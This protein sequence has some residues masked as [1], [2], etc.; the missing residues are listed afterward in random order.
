MHQ[1]TPTPP[2]GRITTQRDGHVLLIGID[3]AKKLNGFSP[4]MLI[5]LAQAMTTL[6]KD[7]AAW[8]GLIYAEG[9]N[10]TAGLELDKVVAYHK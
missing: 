10:F 1:P 5:Q 6:E 4:Q 3:R 7:D 8:V 2:E 9:A